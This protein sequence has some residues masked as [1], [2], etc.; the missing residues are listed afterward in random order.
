MRTRFRTGTLVVRHAHGYVAADA[1]RPRLG[2]ARR[3][4]CS[5]SALWA[6]RAPRALGLRRRDRGLPWDAER[7]GLARS[8]PSRSSSACTRRSTG[9]G[10]CPPTRSCGLL[11]RRLGRRRGRRCATRLEA[12]ALAAPCPPRPRPAA[13]PAPLWAPPAEEAPAARRHRRPGRARRSPTPTGAGAR[14]S[15]GGRRP[16][17]CSSSRSRSRRRGRRSSRCARCTPATRRSSGWRRASSR[18]RSSIAQI[19]HDRNP[20][21]PEP[22]WELGYIEQQRGRLADAEDALERGG[23]APARER[24]GLAPAR[25]LPALRRSTS[26]PTR[27]RRS[28]PPTSSTRAT[29]RR[30]RT[31]SRRAARTGSRPRC[32]PLAPDRARDERLRAA[33]AAPPSGRIRTSAKPVARSARVERAARVEAQVLAQR[34]VVRVEA[35]RARSACAC[36]RPWSGTVSSSRPPGRSTRRTS[37]RQRDRVRDVLEHLRAPDE[38]DLAV[39]E[40]ERAV[41]RRRSRRSAPGTLRRARS[42]AASAISTPTGVGAGVAQ[43]ARRSGPAPQPRSSTRSPGRASPSSSARRR[44]HAHGSGSS[45][46]PPR[47]PRR[48]RARRMV[49]RRAGARAASVRIRCRARC[50]CA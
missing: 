41:G 6:G 9:P 20:L 45:G 40:R 17:R 26:R 12:A 10:S 5:R 1:R 39:A 47:R 7:V 48:S 23:P 16:R 2:R 36:S 46:S 21:S 43:R 29:R 19:A 50:T 25:P 34:V 44:R 35:R 28:G 38:V 30:R 27:S 49:T 22:L 14:R 24:R 42:S 15:R 31:S 4:R 32:R 18:P 8:S 13:D 37:V 3:S 33:A 11:R